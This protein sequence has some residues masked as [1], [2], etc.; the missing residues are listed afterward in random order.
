[1][2][3]TVIKFVVSL[4][5]PEIKKFLSKYIKQ[6]LAWVEDK[7]YEWMRNKNDEKANI[8]EEE[9]RTADSKASAA[10]SESEAYK[11]KAVAEVWRKVAESL[12]KDN[13]S[14]KEEIGSLMASNSTTAKKQLLALE[15][16]DAFNTSS[17][18]I[19]VKQSLPLPVLDNDR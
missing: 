8:A 18:S 12:R 6:M 17:N 19:T 11:H 16:N 3:K 5:W 9:A 1:M 7:I 15:F 14:L 2:W 4:F 10:Q 13:E